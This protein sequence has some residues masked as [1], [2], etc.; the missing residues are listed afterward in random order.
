MNSTKAHIAALSLL[1]RALIATTDEEITTL[2][3]GLPD[4]H[5]S[6]IK[7][8]S[9]VNDDAVAGNELVEAIREA[10]RRGRMNGDLQR[11]GVVLTDV[12]LADCV[13]QLGENAELPTEE[14]LQEVIPGLVERH[15]VGAVRMMFASVVVGEAPA[16]PAIINLLKTDQV[17]Q[18]P[19]AEQKPLAPLLVPK[20]V[21][22][23]V[24]DARKA[25]KAAEQ[26]AAALRR[27]QV[28]RAK[29]RV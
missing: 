26:A 27:G 3:A 2:L 17:I 15:K 1:D 4:D 28:A 11:L 8:I 23:A 18:L 25:R 14:Q 5:V 21:D 7:R 13:E 29:N 20:P 16:S 22:A 9:A 12:C 24:K 10:A 19:A 6:A